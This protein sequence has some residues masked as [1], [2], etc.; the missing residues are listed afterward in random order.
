[1]KVF[2]EQGKLLE[3]HRLRQRTEY[4]LEMMKELGF[5]NGIEN[6]SRILDGRPSGS[7]PY[8]L[9]DY[10]PSDFVCFIDES[11]QTVPQIGGM[12]EGDRSRKQTLV[13]YGFRLPSALD[14]RPLRFDEF[15][16]QVGQM[17]FVSATPGSYEL[18]PRRSS[19][20][21]S[22]ARPAWSTPRSSSARRRT[23]STTCSARSAGASRPTSAC[24]SR[25]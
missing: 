16:G 22:S 24:S 4:D 17:V 23:R 9:L 1:M 6:Y 21:S 10:F 8:T 14:N 13:D 20:S 3:A 5:C 7:A 12:Y 2:E 15:L 11:H 19:P 18:R 25:R